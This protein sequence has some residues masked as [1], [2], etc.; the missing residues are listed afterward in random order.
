MESMYVICFYWQGDRWQTEEYVQ[1]E[2]YVNRQQ[3][4]MN[5]LG[6]IDQDLSAKYVNNLYAGVKRYADRSFEFICF[7]NEQLDGLHPEIT[8]RNFPMLTREGVLPRLF[9]FSEEAGLFGHQVLCLDLDVVIVGSLHDIMEY[10]GVFCTRSK[11]RPAERFKLD[12]D[13]MSFQANEGTQT[14]FWDTFMQ[15]LDANVEMTQGRERYW[16]RHVAGEF[17]ERWDDVAPGSVVSYKWHVKR[18]PVPPGAAI[19]SCHGVPR[20]HQIKDNWIKSYWK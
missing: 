17:A 8:I 1:P 19:V 4:T 7:T 16:V 9:M 15:D 3:K 6:P 14:I 2:G 10:N 20:P 12:G 5:K 13:I 11:F 18:G